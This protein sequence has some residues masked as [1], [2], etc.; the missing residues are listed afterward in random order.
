MAGCLAFQGHLVVKTGKLARCS[1]RVGY[2]R[3]YGNASPYIKICRITR[4][5]DSQHY[6]SPIGDKVL[7][8]SSLPAAMSK[9]Q[10]VAKGD[11]QTI[12]RT[13]TTP[14]KPN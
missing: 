12:V 9:A 8:F 14:I 1:S 4:N 10:Y 7:E 6:T 13:K 2:C 5:K 3:A 11:A